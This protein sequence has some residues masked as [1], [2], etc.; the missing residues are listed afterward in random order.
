M[1]RERKLVEANDVIRQR[2]QRHQKVIQT[3]Q[4]GF[5]RFEESGRLREINE[6]LCRLLDYTPEEMLRL[7]ISDID[8]VLLPAGVD[9]LLARLRK[10]GSLRF[11]TRLRRRDGRQIE[12]EVSLRADQGEYFGFVHDVSEQRRLERE[13]LEISEDERRRFGRSCTMVSDSN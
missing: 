6:S 5:V 10:S 11:S 3:A 12:V 2:E 4:D 9:E 13:V 1:E 7:R 8:A